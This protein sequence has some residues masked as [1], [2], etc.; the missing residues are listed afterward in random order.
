MIKK[1]KNF[2]NI[3]ILLPG[4]SAN[5]ADIAI[6]TQNNLKSLCFT[7]KKKYLNQYK[8]K[9][10]KEIDGINVYH[11]V[12]SLCSSQNPRWN[13]EAKQQIQLH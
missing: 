7:D 13:M 5:I 2:K 10:V 1:E 8:L 12:K 4:D 6:Q 9:R 3:D 11:M